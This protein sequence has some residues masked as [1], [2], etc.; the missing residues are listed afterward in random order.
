VSDEHL[1]ID[2]S[3]LVDLALGDDLGAAVLGRIEGV[4]LHSPA[5]VDAEVLSGLGHL[6]RAGKLTASAV[7][8]Q[9]ATV[10]AAPIERHLL[11]GLIA[12]AWRRR[13]RLRLADALY[14]ELATTLSIP[15]VTTDG[16]LGRSARIA[17]VVTV[18]S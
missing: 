6:H 15:L 3:A 7:G 13:H 18:A 9:L 11:P 1:V 14:V 17:E 4:V 8:Q 16:R 12:G 5:H 2:A 10:A